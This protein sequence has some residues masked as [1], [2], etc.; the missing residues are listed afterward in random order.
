MDK[1]N[2]CKI[3]LI[4]TLRINLNKYQNK[5]QHWFENNKAACTLKLI[6]NYKENKIRMKARFIDFWWYL[7]IAKSPMCL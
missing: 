2:Q 1:K 5:Y 6:K 3:E 7:I 4:T